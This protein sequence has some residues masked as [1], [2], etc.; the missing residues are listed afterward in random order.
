LPNKRSCNANGSSSPRLMTTLNWQHTCEANQYF[1]FMKDST[2]FTC[3]L[4]KKKLLIFLLQPCN[5]I[6]KSTSSAVLFACS[7][8][9]QQLLTK[10]NLLN[11][12]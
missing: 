12:L 8:Q 1:N 5:C 4:S 10:R 6:C 9:H 3:E 11:C 7:L 2:Q